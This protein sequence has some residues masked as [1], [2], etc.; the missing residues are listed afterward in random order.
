MMAAALL[1]AV[2][3]VQPARAKVASWIV[4]EVNSGKVIEQHDAFHRWYPAS[5]TKLMTAYVTFAAL[6]ERRVTMAS[7]VTVSAH[8]AA[9]PPSKMGLKPG[10]QL[11]LDAAM[12]VMLVKSANDIAVAVAETIGGSQAGFADVMNRTAR[13][14]GMRDTHFVNPHGLPDPDHYSSA[15]DMAI[16][17][18]ALLRDFPQ[19]RELYG[20][21]GVQFGRHMLRSANR[22]YL[23]RV[24]GADGLKTGY[25]CNA[26]YN[27]AVSATRGGR[28]VVAVVF[29]AASGLER[30]AKAR[31]L[32]EKG[33]SGGGLFS[34]RKTLDE[35]HRPRTVRRLPP[36]GYC[37]RN[38]KPNVAELL[39]TY[40]G[41]S[42]AR[43]SLSGNANLPGVANAYAGDSGRLARRSPVVPRTTNKTTVPRTGDKKVDWGEVMDRLIG[44]RRQAGELVA[45]TLA[46]DANAKRAVPLRAPKEE[47]PSETIAEA[48]GTVMPPRSKPGAP[49]EAAQT[50][51]RATATGAPLVI[52]P[53]P[54]HAPDGTPTP[55]PSPR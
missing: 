4:F 10:T 15:Y 8:A 52:I 31:Q 6:K 28:T 23:Q 20:Y 2:G 22:E 19:Y 32:I 26:G 41:A 47:D 39:K 34:R 25:I 50:V 12:K 1:F 42:A 40:A 43:A 54:S 18:R 16:L 46:V 14:L 38:K 3:S 13:R 17:S 9:Q 45:V 30:A 37:K 48:F 5:L 27:V 44:P 55:R 36:D 21:A 35:M 51:T 11:S 7:P 33:F 49:P 53:L 29:G 24:R